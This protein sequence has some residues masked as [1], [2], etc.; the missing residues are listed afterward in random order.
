[1]WDPFLYV[2]VSCLSYLLQLVQKA[3][4]QVCLQKLHDNVIKLTSKGGGAAE[5][6]RIESVAL[7]VNIIFIT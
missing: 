6:R 7:V 2:F 5:T 4:S 3:V 1:M